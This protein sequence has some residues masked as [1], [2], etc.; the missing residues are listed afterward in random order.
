MASTPFSYSNL[1]R[2]LRK[3]SYRLSFLESLSETY[4]ES[5]LD[6]VESISDYFSKEVAS[7]IRPSP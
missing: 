1:S 6:I 4:F 2:S 7:R 5:S 3:T